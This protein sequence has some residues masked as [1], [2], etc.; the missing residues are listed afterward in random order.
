[1]GRGFLPCG[2]GI[3][4]LW[5]GDSYLVGRGSPALAIRTGGSRCPVECIPA[6]FQTT[7]AVI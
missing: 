3:L 7:G 6:L 4:N 2:V 1:M 5:G